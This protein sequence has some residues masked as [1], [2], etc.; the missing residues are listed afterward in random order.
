MSAFK[1]Q[2]MRDVCRTFLNQKEFADEHTVN[3]VR[4]PAVI[5]TSSF[6]DSDVQALHQEPLTVYV[7]QGALTLPRPGDAV[8]LDG[9]HYRC[10][11]VRIE[12]GC[13]CIELESVVNL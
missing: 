8:T 12:Q 7:R 9:F 11:A 10:S 3:G 1:S 13:D 4:L 5:D 6:K 2:L